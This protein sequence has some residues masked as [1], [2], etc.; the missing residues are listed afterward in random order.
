MKNSE[1]G[2][3]AVIEGVMM[4]KYKVI[5]QPIGNN[6]AKDFEHELQKILNMESKKGQNFIT[7][8]SIA[9]SKGNHNMCIVFEEKDRPDTCNWG[10]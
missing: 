3:Q 7:M 8:A 10:I 4:K 9:D 1:I 5:C 6:G 2:G